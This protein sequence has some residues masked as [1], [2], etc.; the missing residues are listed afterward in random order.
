M[1]KTLDKIAVSLDYFPRSTFA[2]SAAIHCVGGALIGELVNTVL[3][4]PVFGPKTKIAFALAYGI[5]G[6]KVV[7]TVDEIAKNLMREKDEENFREY[8]K[9]YDSCE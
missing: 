9:V 7:N 4:S 8:V 2:R 6:Y 5:A 1:L 3:E